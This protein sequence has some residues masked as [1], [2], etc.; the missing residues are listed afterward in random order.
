[1]LEMMYERSKADPCVYFNWDRHGELNLWASFID[2]C[3]NAGKR[4]R[5]REAKRKMFRKFE[6]EDVGELREYVGIKIDRDYENGAMRL[7]QPVTLQS[8]ED[9]FDIPEDGED[10][11]LPAAAGSILKKTVKEEESRPLT[12]E[13]HNQY[14][15]GVGKL[16][17]LRTGTREEI[18]NRVRELSQKLANP[19]EADLQAMYRVMRYLLATKNRG[20]YLKPT[21]KWDGKREFEFKMHAVS[22]S[23]YASDPETGRSPGGWTTF[24]EDAPIEAKSKVMPIVALSP[25]ESEL[26][27]M[28]EAVR[29]LLSHK[30]FLES[31]GLKVKTP[32]KVYGDNKGAFDLANN[33]STTG[34]TRHM[35]VK[36][37]FLRDLKEKGLVDVIWIPGPTNCADIFTKNLG[38]KQFEKHAAKFCGVDEYMKY[39]SGGETT[40]PADEAEDDA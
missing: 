21:R 8:L 24:L 25:T 32:M 33:W 39:N 40:Q 27:Y 26:I 1:M 28:T 23:S 36:F 37:Y 19:T 29:A 31:I 9:E 14:R 35:D 2:D 6:C 4:D 34:R 17:W 13:E 38:G 18:S 5:V 10:P 7:T 20:T 30:R 11:S 12:E 16:Q 3:I 15:K 22:D